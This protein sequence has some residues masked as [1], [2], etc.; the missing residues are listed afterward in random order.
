MNTTVTPHTH[1]KVTSLMPVSYPYTFSSPV[2]LLAHLLTLSL[3]LNYFCYQLYPPILT[4]ELQKCL[5][6][7][8][9]VSMIIHMV[10][11]L[12]WNIY[13]RLE[14]KSFQFPSPSMVSEQGIILCNM[15]HC[16]PK[17]SCLCYYCSFKT[18]MCSTDYESKHIQS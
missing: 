12:D 5:H 10:K 6:Q 8:S 18:L 9:R 3:S 17:S 2:W 4:A 16:T 11:N 15:Y 14:A 13:Y 1:N 7:F